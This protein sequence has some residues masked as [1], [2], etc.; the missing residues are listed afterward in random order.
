MMKVST[1]STYAIRALVDLARSSLEHPERLASIAERQNIPLPF[2][3]Q[4]FLKLKNAG[5]VQAVRGPQGGYQL[6]KSPADLS[7][8]DVVKVLDGPIEPVLCSQPH[9]KSE[10]CHEVD[11]CMS[12]HLCSE[13]DGA[14]YQILSK[15]TVEQLLS[16]S[17]RLENRTV[18]FDS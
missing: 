1:K 11:G 17:E 9:K 14:V 2:L 7:L 15:N 13:L 12:R 18:K 4:I 8:A 5:L 10:N 6:A 3:E 16:E